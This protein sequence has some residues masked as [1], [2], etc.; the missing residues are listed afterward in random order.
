MQGVGAGTIPRM[1]FEPTFRLT[2][3]IQRQLVAIDM[4]R[5]FLDAVR[6]RDDWSARVRHQVRIEDALA[7]LQIEG[8]SLTLEAA[9]Q[10]A[11]ERDRPRDL[12]E[13]GLELLNY[14][15]AFDAVDSL[16][17]DRDA[18]LRLGDV[19]NIHRML[20]AGVR[21]GD[22]YAGELRRESVAVGDIVD[23]Q[24]V[25]HHEPPPWG[26]VEG[27]LAE[28]FAWIEQVKAKPRSASAEDRWMHPVLV[29]GLA[30]QRFVW[31]H[32][33]VDGNGRSARMLT[34]LLLFQ[35]GYDFKY[36]FNLSQYYNHDRDKY[37]AALRTADASGDYTEWLE[38]FCGGLARQMYLVRSRAT[39][40]A[41]G[42]EA[43]EGV[44][45]PS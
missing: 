4:T 31:I 13:S 11:A 32:P 35:R 22:R 38:Y 16:R 10:I 12:Q 28:L 27:Y 42:V 7:S 5:G 34:T 1:L 26:Q 37:Y 8:S 41:G 19:R 43:E 40:A 30:Q 23:G 15:R 20:V 39:E 14:L 44:G 33:F 36:L 9:F 24:T 21:G 29:A 45:D 3:R 25:I 2:P 6:L 18:V 17:G